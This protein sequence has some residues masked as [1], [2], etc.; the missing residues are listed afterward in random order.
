[1]Y[2]NDLPIDLELHPVKNLKEKCNM[3]HI[4]LAKDNK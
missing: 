2:C 1:M 4:C 3:T